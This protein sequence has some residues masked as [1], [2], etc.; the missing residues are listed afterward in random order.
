MKAVEIPQGFQRWSQAW[1]PP[2]L[3]RI[4]RP[5]WSDPVVQYAWEVTEPYDVVYWALT[6]ISAME[7][8]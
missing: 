4:W 6:G 2:M 1:P 8:E 7:Q 5:S 3:L